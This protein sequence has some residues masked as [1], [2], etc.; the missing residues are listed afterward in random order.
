[1]EKAFKEIS[2]T[3]AWVYLVQNVDLEE[4]AVLYDLCTPNLG[5]TLLTMLSLC[6]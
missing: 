2:R 5:T 3:I 6:L 1:M 4:V